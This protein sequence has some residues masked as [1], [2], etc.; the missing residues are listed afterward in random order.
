MSR[1][2]TEVRNGK[3]LEQLDSNELGIVASAY[4]IDSGSDT[5]KIEALHNLT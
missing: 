2:I 4:G 3:S 1:V 5:Q